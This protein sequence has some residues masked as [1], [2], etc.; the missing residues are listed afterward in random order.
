MLYKHMYTTRKQ[1]LSHTHMHRHT[2]THTHYS[3]DI[4]LVLLTFTSSRQWLVVV[5]ST[6]RGLTV[7][8]SLTRPSDPCRPASSHPPSIWGHRRDSIFRYGRGAF[9]SSTRFST[10]APLCRLTAWEWCTGSATFYREHPF[11]WANNTHREDWCRLH[12]F[13]C[14][15]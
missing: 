5:L 3:P 10:H 15:I 11:Q 4:L 14:K 1:K 7:T 13:L 9:Y 2:H 8:P 6:A 12:H